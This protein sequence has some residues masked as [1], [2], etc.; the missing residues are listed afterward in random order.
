MLSTIDPVDITELQAHNRNRLQGH[1]GG[2]FFSMKSP[3]VRRVLTISLLAA[4]AC[5]VPSV[6]L[7]ASHHAKSQIFGLKKVIA[8]TYCF[9]KG[10]DFK[11]L[12]SVTLIGP[13]GVAD[14]K[15]WTPRGVAVGMGHG[16]GDLIHS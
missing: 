4:A 3:L 14:W 13:L 12:K 9:P 6:R 16:W 5:A 1:H 15:Y 2:G 10:Y 8:F 11:Q 7:I